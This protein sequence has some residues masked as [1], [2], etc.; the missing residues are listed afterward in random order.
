[1]PNR[2]LLL[3]QLGNLALDLSL[4]VIDLRHFDRDHPRLRRFLP[5]E[6]LDLLLVGR[7]RLTHLLKRLLDAHE[8]LLLSLHLSLHLRKFLLVV[9]D[10][11]WLGR[12]GWLAHI[13]NLWLFFIVAVLLESRLLLEVPHHVFAAFLLQEGHLGG[14]CFRLFLDWLF[15][16]VLANIK[17]L[18]QLHDFLDD[19]V[20]DKLSADLFAVI[21]R[22][23]RQNN[24]DRKDKHL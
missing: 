22:D 14:A 6:S 18:L 7:A 13:D 20:S 21:S 17:L 16:F 9:S 1:M 23:E 10:Q 8:L 11:V 19:G 4:G 24:D 3:L 12:I 5:D 2:I 15:R